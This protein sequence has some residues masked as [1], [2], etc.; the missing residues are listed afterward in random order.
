MNRN[1]SWQSFM[2]DNDNFALP[3]Y[4]Y[5]TISD[6]MK[7]SLD[8][9]TLLSNDS[10]KLRAYKEQIKTL[11][12]K[13]WMEMAQALEFF[14][15]IVPCGCSPDQYCKIC[16]GSRYMLHEALSPDTLRE[17]AFVM[18][19]DADAETTKKLEEGLTKAIQ[20]THRG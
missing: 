3:N 10:V 19:P 11:F 4:I 5:A 12:K 1:L 9:G 7:Q 17:I 16:G 8:L 20:Q 2:D 13:R 15:I 6:L 14:E 18:G